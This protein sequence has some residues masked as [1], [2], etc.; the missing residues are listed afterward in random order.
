MGD[1]TQPVDN[2]SFHFP[3]NSDLYRGDWPLVRVDH[4]LTSKNSLFVR[5]LMRETPYVLNNGLPDLVW[6]RKRKHQQ[7]AAGDTHIFTS[8]L[9][10]N[11]RFG[12]SSDYIVDGQTEAGQTPPDG[13]AMLATT[14]LQG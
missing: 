9:I 2:Y 14:G 12:Y 1:P 13:S 4:A 10:N 11:F 3:F 5:W 7:W 6:T 8:Q